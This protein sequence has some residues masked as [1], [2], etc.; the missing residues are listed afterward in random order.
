MTERQVLECM[1]QVA[2]KEYNNTGDEWWFELGVTIARKVGRRKKV[3][4]IQK[5]EN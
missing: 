2:A 3:Q 4:T 1:M 5:K